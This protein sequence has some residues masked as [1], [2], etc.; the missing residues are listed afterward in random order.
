MFDRLQDGVGLRTSD[1]NMIIDLLMGAEQHVMG[2]EFFAKTP[3]MVALAIE[4]ATF[5]LPRA[6]FF[7]IVGVLALF[8]LYLIYLAFGGRNLYW[9]L[10]GLAFFFLLLPALLEGLSYFGDILATYG[11]MPSLHRLSS[12]SIMQ[13]ILAQM[14]WSVMIFLVVV[15][16]SWGLRGIAIQF[17]LIQ[18]RRQPPTTAQTGV[19]STSETNPTLTSETIVEW[20]EEF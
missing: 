12:A 9:R 14:A 5:G 4:R 3:F 18:D 19:S 16:A 1:I 17:G 7:I 6:I 20:D 11:N 2:E 13:N 15:F 10:L 8:P